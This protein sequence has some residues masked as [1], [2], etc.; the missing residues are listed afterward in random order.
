M[1]ETG[2]T[3]AQST[4]APEEYAAFERWRQPAEGDQPPEQETSDGAG[5]KPE[6]KTGSESET[7]TKQET[8]KEERPKKDRIQKRFDQLT[9]EKYEL[10]ARIEALERRLAQGGDHSQ[11]AGEPPAGPPRQEDFESYEDYVEARAIWKMEQKLAE[12]EQRM[13][14]REAQ[15]QAQE[16]MRRWSAR[17]EAARSKYEDF[18]EALDTDVKITPAIQQAL[19]ESEAGAEIAYYLGK[20]PE[21]AARI[22]AL[23]PV[24]AIR[25]I[26]KIEAKLT[27]SPSEQKPKVSNAPPPARTLMGRAAAAD[28]SDPKLSYEEWERLRNAQLRKR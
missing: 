23:T 21:E 10:M 22:A 1:A 5:E 14:E 11:P 3:A 6:A 8:D 25:E 2:N 7:E 27:S 19:M 24:A 20:H 4:A 17:V 28:L 26:G 16:T 9:R 13:A 12:R 18:D 15:Q